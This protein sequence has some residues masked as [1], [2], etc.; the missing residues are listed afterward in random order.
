MSSR[1]AGSARLRLLNEGTR[2]FAARG[3]HATT[4]DAIVRAAGLSKRMVY[5]YFGNKEG[6][7]REVLIAIYSRLEK[8]E[9][10]PLRTTDD[11]EK[12]VEALFD[13]YFSFLNDNPDFV[14]I[15]LWENLNEGRAIRS[16]DH[17][18]SKGVVLTK[19]EAVLARGIR[20]GQFRRDVDARHLFINLVGLCFIY[21]S[22]R[23]TLSQGLA[24]DL[25]DETIIRQARDHA[26][27]VLFNGISAR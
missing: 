15:L 20:N 26:R 18:L 2:L 14:R 22:N 23:Y 27:T 3:Y 7:Y 5:H 13:A 25:S 17:L 9:G 24:L 8:I 16:H 10:E 21:H 12:V 6:L 1:P 11:P 4:V 19:L